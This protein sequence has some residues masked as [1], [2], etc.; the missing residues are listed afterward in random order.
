MKVLVS[1]S[2]VLFDL[3]RYQLIRQI[4]NLPY[5]FIVPDI[6][7]ATEL[8]RDGNQTVD[9]IRVLFRVE[10]LS[11]EELI[12]LGAYGS[13][14]PQ[15][16]VPDCAALALVE[17]REWSLLAGDSLMRQVAMDPSHEV[18][19]TLWVL[20]EYL[21]HGLVKQGVIAKS[22]EGMLQDPRIRLPHSELRKRLKKLGKP[23]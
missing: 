12:L 3:L 21:H 14:F 18:K 7:L 6:T 2:S 15:L 19:G 8:F 13:K 9:L 16:S 10:S 20:D 22:L 1:D 11:P 23:G 4:A 5:E 17:S